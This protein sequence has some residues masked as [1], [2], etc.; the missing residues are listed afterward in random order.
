MCQKRQFLCQKCPSMCH[1][2]AKT[3]QKCRFA[4]VNGCDWRRKKLTKYSPLPQRQAGRG[5][6]QR[7][8]DIP[9]RLR[10]SIRRHEQHE[11]SR[12]RTNSERSSPSLRPS[13]CGAVLHGFQQLCCFASVHPHRSDLWASI[14]IRPHLATIPIYS[15]QRSALTR[16]GRHMLFLLDRL[17]YGLRIPQGSL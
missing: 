4:P 13:P 14:G 2:C 1:F 7:N 5:L 17:A 15:S 9:A 11:R 12:Q 16:K 6:K 3:G 8:A 10:K